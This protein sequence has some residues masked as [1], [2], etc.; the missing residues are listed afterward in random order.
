MHCKK[1]LAIFPVP[2]R[3][4]TSQTLLG[5]EQLNYSR[6][7]MVWLVTSRLGTGKSLTYFYSA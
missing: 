1:K 5:R 6:P 4:V 3:D 2:R 7:G